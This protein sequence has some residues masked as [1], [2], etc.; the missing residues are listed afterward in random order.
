M[1]LIDGAMEYG[2]HAIAM[3]ENTEMLV[4]GY[5]RSFRVIPSDIIQLIDNF[6]LIEYIYLIQHDDDNNFHR[7]LVD[8]IL[9]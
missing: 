6:V 3:I 2:I 4:N 9:G 8:D 1:D 7:I 5:L